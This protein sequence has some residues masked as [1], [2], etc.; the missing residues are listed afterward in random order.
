MKYTSEQKV[1]QLRSEIYNTLCP[2]ISNK[3]IYL[4]LPYHEN[5]GDILIW[6][7]TEQFIKSSKIKCIYKSS[8]T[9][10]QYKTISPDTTILLH[11]GG[12]FGD[13]WKKHQEFRLKIIQE[14]PYNRIIILPQTVYY[15]DTQN[16]TN[17]ALIMSKHPNLFICGRDNVSYQILKDHFPQNNILLVPDMAFCILTENLKHKQI[18]TSKKTLLIRRTDKEFKPF[19]LTSLKLNANEIDIRDWP[20]LERK[21]RF[22]SLYYNLSAINDTLNQSCNVILDWYADQIV[23]PQLISLGFS[24]INQYENIYTTRLHT[25]ILAMLLHKKFTFLDNSYKKNS[26]FYDTWLSDIKDSIFIRI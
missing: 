25:A 20:S 1:E 23:R 19:N 21:R 15:E 24:F 6:E 22:M 9:T 4:D 11:G 10:Y 12:N 26:Q 2:I 8:I 17:D 5:I 3:C 14:Y 13:I 18:D 16:I 7:G